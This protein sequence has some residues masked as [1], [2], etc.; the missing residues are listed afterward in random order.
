MRG[1]NELL[2]NWRHGHAP[3]NISSDYKLSTIQKDKALWWKN[4]ALRTDDGL[5][6]N[7]T[8]KDK[9]RALIHSATVQIFDREFSSPYRFTGELVET[10]PVDINKKKSIVYRGQNA[11]GTFGATAY[12]DKWLRIV[13]DYIESDQD[14]ND[15]KAIRDIKK[16]D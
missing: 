1:V 11:G 7:D 12:P 16:K 8:D 5:T 4:Q 13:S 2:Y 10:N 15:D 14:I 9:S 6:L 3:E